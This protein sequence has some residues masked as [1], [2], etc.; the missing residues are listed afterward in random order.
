M[1]RIVAGRLRMVPGGIREPALRGSEAHG[2][3]GRAK[4]VMGLAGFAMLWNVVSGILIGLQQ[5]WFG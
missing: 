1:A 2:A 4:I 3:R 5:G